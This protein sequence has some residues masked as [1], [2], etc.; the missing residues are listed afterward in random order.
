M[1]S[2]KAIRN[3]VRVAKKLRRG[4]KLDIDKYPTH[5]LPNV[6]RQV[7]AEGGQVEP[8]GE[9]IKNDFIP[10]G[11]PS[12]SQ[13]LAQFIEG[14]HPDVPNVLY[15]GTNAN[16]NKFN[17]GSRGFVSLAT[18]PS[19][20]SIYAEDYGNGES[21]SVLPVYVSAKNPFNFEDPKHLDVIKSKLGDL[22]RQRPDLMDDIASGDWSALEMRVVQQ[23]IKRLG[24][25]SFF[26][27]ET[28]PETGDKY[29]NLGVFSPSQIKS[30]TGNQG[31]FDPSNSDITKAE[32]GPISPN[33][34]PAP[35]PNEIGLYSHGAYAAANL[36][37]PRGTPQQYRSML[38]KQGVKPDE[39]IHTGWDEAFANR[40]SVTR[41]EVAQHFQQNAPILS[42]TTASKY[43]GKTY[44]NTQG[45]KNY[46]EVLLRYDG[47]PTGNIV[48]KDKSDPSMHWSFSNR[49]EAENFINSRNNPSEEYEI[50]PENYV[51]NYKSPHWDIPN[52]VAHIRMKDRVGPNGEKILHVEEIQSD[53]AQQARRSGFMDSEEIQKANDDLE[54]NKIKYTQAMNDSNALRDVIAS[55]DPSNREEAERQLKI[56]IEREKQARDN[57]LNSRE[58]IGVENAPF[59][60]NTNKWV[61]LAIKRVIKEAAH[62]DYDHVIF[63]SGDEQAERSQQRFP[64]K[65][66]DYAQ[67]KDGTYEIMLS[68]A[69]SDGIRLDRF[70]ESWMKGVNPNKVTI[71]DIKKIFGEDVANKV[72][73]NQSKPSFGV[74][75]R[76]AN[77]NKIIGGEGVKKFYDDVLMKRLKETSKK[78]NPESKIQ[79]TFMNFK[80][81][82][83]GDKDMRGTSLIKGDVP[84]IKMQITPKMKEVVRRGLPMFAKGGEVSKGLTFGEPEEY[85]VGS[86]VVDQGDDSSPPLSPSIHN[87]RPSSTVSFSKNP[88]KE[89]I[90]TNQPKG[91]VSDNSSV[92][93]ALVL[94]SSALNGRAN[95]GTPR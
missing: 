88:K 32:G 62:G 61:D 81:Q 85:E 10:H 41:E 82:R 90:K 58:K 92:R 67:N 6:G 36:S 76:I 15:H 18:H 52:V 72:L 69:K 63:T 35:Q 26:M 48:V 64:V 28:D 94:T 7:M 66:I 12:R 4:P 74:W 30:A 56:S 93:K 44:Y 27:S 3:A 33:V 80:G 16:F 53:W 25:D 77:V 65:A 23:A 79:T 13:N 11:H 60:D 84:Y 5:Y 19:F 9:G 87:T 2:K 75:R 95:R 47:S 89:K 22:I 68:N 14:N 55:L 31:T 40:P 91:G 49:N 73:N 21:P 78:I 42:E 50:N 59:V 83:F 70:K 34:A 54:S 51:T 29:K 20:A 17:P 57:Y 46:R 37:Q 45:G 71:D 38:E 8:E 24:H 1:M 39:F 43:V 86:R